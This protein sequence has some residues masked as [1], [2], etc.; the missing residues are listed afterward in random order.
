VIRCTQA[1]E[2]CHHKRRSFPH[3][4]AIPRLNSPATPR[5]QHISCQAIRRTQRLGSHACDSLLRS[6]PDQPSVLL[7][8]IRSVG[9]EGGGEPR[10]DQFFQ[11]ASNF[12]TSLF[13][14]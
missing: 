13:R 1:G 8:C 3:P 10:S 7:N 12:D 2:L 6:H 14:L 5:G 9:A 11:T 4:L